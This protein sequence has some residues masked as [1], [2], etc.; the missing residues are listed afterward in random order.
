MTGDHAREWTSVPRRSRRDDGARPIPPNRA[1]TPVRASQFWVLGFCRVNQTRDAPSWPS[2][3]HLWAPWSRASDRGRSRDARRRA[4]LRTEWR[5]T[6]G[7][8]FSQIRRKPRNRSPRPPR[9]LSC[10]RF[11]CRCIRPIHVKSVSSR[12]RHFDRA[13]W[14][15]S[16]H[17]RRWHRASPPPRVAASRARRRLAGG[18]RAAASRLEGPM[19][20]RRARSRQRTAPSARWTPCSACPATKTTRPPRRNRTVSSRTRT[21]KSRRAIPPKTT[22]SRRRRRVTPPA[23]RRQPSTVFQRTTMVK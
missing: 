18:A 5:G 16:C 11:A 1:P 2:W 6:S 20:V 7:R 21:A 17:A 9:D 3:R 23:E 14:P 10:A 15:R 22:R 8:R 19:T 13:P 12:A 4:A